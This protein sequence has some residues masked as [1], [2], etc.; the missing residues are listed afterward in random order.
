MKKREF[1]QAACI[2]FMPALDWD[3]VKAMA[4]AEKLWER[5]DA[6]GYGEP[7]QNGPHEIARAYDKLTPIMK[8]AFYL[9]W[10]AFDYKAKKDRTAAKWLQMGELSKGEYDKII[11]GAKREAAKRK[12][13]PEGQVAKMAE[14]WLA[15]R[16]WMDTE[17]TPVD[18]AQKQAAQRAQAMQ[19]LN[20]DLAHAKKMADQ[21]G[22]PY[23]S[24]EVNK[25]TQQLR[26]QRSAHE[27]T[28]SHC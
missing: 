10:L 14:G 9:F 7:K 2:Q 1:I 4:Y 23:W 19:K 22:D 21:T 18:Q 6:K 12:N 25:L 24:D 16:R 17:E 28:N 27:Q 13:L 26:N 3:M 11:A 15:E 8:T 20:Q 5:L